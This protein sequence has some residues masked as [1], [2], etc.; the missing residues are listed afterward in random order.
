MSCKGNCFFSFN[1]NM[2]KNLHDSIF[3]IIFAELLKFNLIFNN[4]TF[5]NV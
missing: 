2:V 4:N 3:C 1:Q 5:L